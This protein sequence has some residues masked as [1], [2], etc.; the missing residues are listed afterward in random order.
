[1]EIRVTLERVAATVGRVELVEPPIVRYHEC[2][3]IV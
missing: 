2:Q 1:M 3:V